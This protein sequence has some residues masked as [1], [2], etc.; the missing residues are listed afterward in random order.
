MYFNVQSKKTT[1]MK[2]Y[3]QLIFTA[4]DWYGSPIDIGLLNEDAWYSDYKL[5]T[6]VYSRN[7]DAMVQKNKKHTRSSSFHIYKTH[8]PTQQGGAKNY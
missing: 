3:I 2:P 6:A 8:L 4:L 7:D 5:N 1:E